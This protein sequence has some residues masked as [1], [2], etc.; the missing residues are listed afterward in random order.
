MDDEVIF[1]AR[2][3]VNQVEVHVRRDG[4]LS[5]RP[6]T[7]ADATTSAPAH[8]VVRPGVI[9]PWRSSWEGVTKIRFSIALAPVEP[10]IATDRFQL[11]LK[12]NEQR[13]VTIRALD[14]YAP[15]VED[16]VRYAL[17]HRPD[18]PARQYRTRDGGYPPTEPLGF[19]IEG[20]DIPGIGTEDEGTASPDYPA[21]FFAAWVDNRH[22]PI[23]NPRLPREIW[24]ELG[25]ISSTGDV[26]H[27]HDTALFTIAPFIFSCDLD[28]PLKL[29][30]RY[31]APLGV[32]GTAAM[33]MVEF[34]MDYTAGSWDSGNYAA[35]YTI[36]QECVRRNIPVDVSTHAH[37][38][39]Q[40]YQFVGYTQT[41]TLGH[42]VML[43][44]IRSGKNAQM[45][46]QPDVIQGLRTSYSNAQRL[47]DGDNSLD[48]GGNIVATP[49]IGDETDGIDAGNAGPVVLD[50]PAAPYGKIIYCDNGGNRRPG[51]RTRD[52]L[53]R[54]MV[55]PLIPI[56][57]AALRVGHA[58]E[59]VSFVG[60]GHE[61]SWSMVYAAPDV[62]WTL[63][64]RARAYT[65][66]RGPGRGRA[67]GGVPEFHPDLNGYPRNYANHLGVGRALLPNA[68]A[69][70][71]KLID[72][73]ARLQHTLGDLPDDRVLRTPVPFDLSANG[74]DSPLPNMVNLQ[75][76]GSL[77]FVP[78]PWGP[79]LA[80]ADVATLLVGVEG[81]TARD[82][83]L[84][85][86]AELRS[87]EVWLHEDH[88]M[89]GFDSMMGLVEPIGY[90]SDDPP[91]PYPT[92]DDTADVEPP[93]GMVRH[94]FGQN[95]VCVFEAYMRCKLV[96]IGI[97]PVFVDTWA[98]YHNS[99]G[100]IHCG[101]NALR[102]P[103]EVGGD[104]RW[105][106]NYDRWAP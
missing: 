106:V 50:H 48:F 1:G 32:P 36:W 17:G 81:L 40:D 37:K 61:R 54:Q 105:W 90:T 93:D 43:H 94:I 4:V 53:R 52:F 11:S 28:R 65:L 55:Q 73:Q 21:P 69:F 41:P 64:D 24:L 58:D 18:A 19:A 15:R 59:V 84:G 87:E 6:C 104:D 14:D 70:I 16:A 33:N 25:N 23:Q 103:P 30:I 51:Q 98:H 60:H 35:I 3:N 68:S 49:P 2:D 95:S 79:R 71:Q 66:H 42:A 7:S 39:L 13:Q 82:V 46:P 91:G 45:L 99:N 12:A 83:R 86:L 76:L 96:K 77:V 29:F 20:V 56:D 38:W 80:V 31:G 26:T 5:T 78:K 74:V 97:T 34:T 88:P 102:H 22:G 44:M 62:A 85:N 75:V 67:E 89:S 63:I 101:T 72:V 10:D 100:Q 9:V 8:K 57:V 47:V 92:I 27:G